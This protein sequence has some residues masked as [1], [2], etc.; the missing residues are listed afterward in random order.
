MVP[1]LASEM[2]DWWDFEKA[3]W[4]ENLSAVELVVTLADKMV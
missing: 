3:R 2:V 4:R 1:S